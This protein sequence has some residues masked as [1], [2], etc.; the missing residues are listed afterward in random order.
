M[1]ILIGQYDS[2]FV[3]RVGIA[4]RLYNM[5]FEHRPWSV[6]ADAEKIS[7][8]NPLGRVPVLVLET[9]FALTDSHAILDYLDSLVAQPLYPRTEPQ[10][11]QVM[12]VAALATGL[13]DKAVGLVYER[14]MHQPPSALWERRCT[15]QITAVLRCLEADRAG[16]NSPWWFGAQMTHAD[17]AVACALRFVVQAH[18]EIY[19]SACP[20]LTAHSAACESLAVFRQINQ[21]FNGPA[22]R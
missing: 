2:P 11:H 14:S 13:A 7:T 4:L 6:F 12:K 1:T 5:P 19:L 10:R 20:A 22:A 3:R 9:G 18:P 15:D 8:I 17:I 16:R 21:P